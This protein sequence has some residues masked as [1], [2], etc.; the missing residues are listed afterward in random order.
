MDPEVGETSPQ[1]DGHE[2]THPG[3]LEVGQV[4]QGTTQDLPV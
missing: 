1:L 3:A 4:V 2:S